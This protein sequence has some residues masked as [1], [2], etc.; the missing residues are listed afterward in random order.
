MALAVL[1]AAIAFTPSGPPRFTQQ[2]TEP[3]EIVREQLSCLQRGED[4]DLN[5]FMSF[6]DYEG[7]FAEQ[8]YSSAPDGPIV[9]FRSK[10]RREPR[11]RRIGQ[12][13]V[14]ALLYHKSADII[15]G[16]NKGFVDGS[17]FRVRVRVQP[18]FKDAPEAESAV[19]FEWLLKRQLVGSL[20]KPETIWKVDNIAADF[21]GWFV[22]ADAGTHGREDE[23]AAKARML[24]EQ[25]AMR[26][27]LFGI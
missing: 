19:L 5:K 9:L 24:E 4:E 14:A 11:W 17:T 25:A 26:D 27:S 10:I 15:K 6:V 2:A 12:R 21:S 18:Y 3:L 23:E 22:D 13:P 16:A 8:F 7:P 1:A 20:A